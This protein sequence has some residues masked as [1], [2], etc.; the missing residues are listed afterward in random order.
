[1]ARKPQASLCQKC[2]GSVT[3]R[4]TTVPE[5]RISAIRNFEGAVEREIL[6]FK[7]IVNSLKT[8]QGLVERPRS[9]GRVE[10]IPRGRL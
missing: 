10:G 2:P 4:N 9:T 3:E 8:S 5:R 7:A 6:R 1:M